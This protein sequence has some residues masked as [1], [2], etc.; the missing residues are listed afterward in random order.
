MHALRLIFVLACLGCVAYEAENVPWEGHLMAPGRHPAIVE[1]GRSPIWAP[2]PEPT[3]ATFEDFRGFPDFP[4]QGTP[5]LEIR[6][7][8]AVDWIEMD[9]ML[10][11]WA[12]TVTCGLVYLAVRGR[13]RDIVLHLVLWA[14]IGLTA[15]IALSM[16]RWLAVR[17]PAYELWFGGLGLVGGIVGGLLSFRREGGEPGA[18]ADGGGR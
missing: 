1:L 13:R 14:G 11:L 3:Y 17:G 8:L 7:V 15:G 18:A 4:D 10:Y 2:P 6:R 12:V 5:G 16:M 9:L